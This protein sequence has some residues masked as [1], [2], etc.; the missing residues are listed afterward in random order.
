MLREL[1][2]LAAVM[3]A[4]LPSAAVVHYDERTSGDIGANG[5]R[6]FEFAQGVN[7]ISGE[8]TDLVTFDGERN[9][10]QLDFDAFEV[11]LASTLR[12]K[13]ATA[14][15][16]FVPLNENLVMFDMRWHVFDF[17]G[18]SVQFTNCFSVLANGRCNADSD[19]GA[20]GD[21]RKWNRTHHFVVDPIAEYVPLDT[22]QTYGGTVEYVLS[23]AV[24][25]V[26]E[27]PMYALWLLGLPLLAL[28]QLRRARS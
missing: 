27:A 23:F 21:V 7:S 28:R 17:P 12:V 10:Y 25:P 18:L 22:K 11:N 8:K 24:A 2:V 26:P 14:A 3:L 15:F 6:L 5:I 4:T 9:R 19:G 1:F 20:L 13:S 16:R